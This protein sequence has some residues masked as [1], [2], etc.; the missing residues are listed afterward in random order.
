MRSYEEI[1]KAFTIW[2][3]HYE[4]M[5]PAK[6]EAQD[7]YG[8][9]WTIERGTLWNE[10]VTR[11][12][13]EVGKIIPQRKNRCSQFAVQWMTVKQDVIWCV[14]APWFIGRTRED[15]GIVFLF[16]SYRCSRS[17]VHKIVHRVLSFWKLLS[18]WVL[19]L[20]TD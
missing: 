14:I 1:Y 11:D 20:L 8:D 13:G 16:A 5:Y 19:R 2:S 7:K 4:Y 10:Y 9:S 12:D 18:R 3:S 17:S 15:F 6:C